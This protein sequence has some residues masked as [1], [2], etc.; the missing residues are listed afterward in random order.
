MEIDLEH[1][2]MLD[3]GCPQDSPAKAFPFQ[4]LYDYVLVEPLPEG[5]TTQGSLY[6]P[7][8]TRDA[9]GFAPHLDCALLRGRVVAVGPGDLTRKLSDGRHAFLRPGGAR[10]PMQVTTGNIVVYPHRG[11]QDVTIEGKRYVLLHEEQSVVAVLEDSGNG[12]L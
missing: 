8:I 2:R 5:H 10:F 9:R 1:S 3:E 12:C 11:G 7:Q 6:L 4:P